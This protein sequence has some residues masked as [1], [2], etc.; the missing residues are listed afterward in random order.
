[1]RQEKIIPANDFPSPVKRKVIVGH[2][3][4]LFLLM[5]HLNNLSFHW[6]ISL[7]LLL[8]YQLLSF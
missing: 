4:L 8:S 3:F 6:I 7:L 2:T 1:M 5:A